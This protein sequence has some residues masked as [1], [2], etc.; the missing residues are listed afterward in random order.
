MKVSK[1]TLRV[2]RLLSF[3]KRN[4]LQV[5]TAPAA[6]DSAPVATE[7]MTRFFFVVVE[8]DNEESNIKMMESVVRLAETLQLPD[9][10]HIRASYEVSPEV[11]R[12][13]I[14]M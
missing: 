6:P 4:L 12:V 10:C 13:V 8:V 7:A 1:M 3:V 5:F 2:S 14:S 11:A 9:G